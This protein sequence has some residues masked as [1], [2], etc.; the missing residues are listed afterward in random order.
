MRVGCGST[1]ARRPAPWAHGRIGPGHG[2]DA[3]C[4]DR[5]QATRQTA[6]GADAPQRERVGCARVMCFAWRPFEQLQ[7]RVA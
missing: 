7:P 1:A 5:A 3:C 4:R 6:C 2:P